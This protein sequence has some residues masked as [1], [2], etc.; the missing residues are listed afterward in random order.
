M[1]RNSME[2]S[3]ANRSRVQ[4]SRHQNDAVLFAWRSR[5]ISGLIVDVPS[6]WS[7]AIDQL[8]FGDETTSKTDPYFCR[9]YSRGPVQSR[10]PDRNEVESIENP[11]QAW[12]AITVGAYTEKAILTD[13]S[14][15]GWE[16]V[17]PVGD[18]EPCQPHFCH[19]GT[20]VAAQ[21][22]HCSRRWELGGAWRSM[23][24]P[25]RS[26]HPY[27]LPRPTIRHFDIFRDTS[28]ATAIAA[29]LAWKAPG[30]RCRNDG[31]RPF[32]R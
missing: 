6:S 24:L 25:R 19:L 16:P 17:A 18:L 1:I 5:A 23:R 30:R 3:L 28:A 20:S 13:P 7:A 14:Y 27:N 26:R 29:N 12:N 15:A 11:A 2:P 22:R 8:C 10:L 32:E 31:P 9:E 4:K 21:T